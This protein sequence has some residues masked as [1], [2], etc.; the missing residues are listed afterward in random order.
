VIP[1]KKLYFYNHYLTTFITTFSFIFTL[2]F[3]FLSSPLPIPHFLCQFIVVS[4]VIIKMVVQITQ[5]ISYRPCMDLLIFFILREYGPFNFSTSIEPFLSIGLLIRS[6][7]KY[8]SDVNMQ[9]ASVRRSD[10]ALP[11]NN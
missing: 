9:S 1:Y 10:K 8:F 6:K 2:C 5:F 7:F 4:K 11:K 3:Y